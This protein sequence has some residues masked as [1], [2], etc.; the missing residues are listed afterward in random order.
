V[1]LDIFGGFVIYWIT[2]AAKQDCDGVGQM[3]LGKT[4]VEVFPLLS[5][6]TSENG[7]CR[8]RNKKTEHLYKLFWLFILLLALNTVC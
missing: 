8:F 3:G 4:V 2:I 1:S 7:F 5:V 6:C